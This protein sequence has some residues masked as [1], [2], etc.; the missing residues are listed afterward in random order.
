MS[1]AGQISDHP[2]S[3]GLERDAR[4]MHADRGTDAGKIALGVILGR[5]SEFFDFFI[6]A[7]ASVL[8][9]P[10]HFFPNFQPLEG[11]LLSFAVFSLAFIARP[12]GTVVFTVIDR[13]YGRGTKLIIALFVLGGSTAAMSFLPGYA[14]IGYWAAAML[15]VLRLGQGFALGGAWDGLASLLALNAPNNRRGWYAMM[16][17]LGAPLGFLLAAG[18]F[19]YFVLA[20][21]T[22]DFLEWG[23]RYPFFVAFAINV[24][25]LFARLRLVATREFGELLERAELMPV[26]TVDLIR[27]RGVDVVI[28]TFIPLASFAMFH[29][30]TVFPLSWITLYSDHPV[31]SFLLVEMLGACICIGTIILSGMLADKIG[32]R[33]QLTVS[34]VLIAIFAVTAP[35][36]LDMGRSGQDAF[37]LLGF[38]VLGLSF[39]QAAG[40]AA[41]RFGR[42]YRYS[43]AALTSNLAWLI[44]AGFAP[45]VALS[46]AHAFGVAYVGIYLMSGA[47]CTLVALYFSKT[48]ETADD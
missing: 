19:T 24:V 26:K 30:V 20:L 47:V 11:I 12:V 40:A 45:L 7:I 15:I 5:S 23:W 31:H 43:G 29:L 32:R 41:S 35:F 22:E 28:G 16:P 39:G 14:E 10:S 6:Y 13:L 4:F 25:A 33:G 38:A 3:A 1:V 46:V 17:Q 27:N 9:F 44:G 48:V 34:A 37:V 42:V 36:L 21:K 2:N 8:V 18:L